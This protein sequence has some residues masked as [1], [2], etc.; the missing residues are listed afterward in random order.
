[1]GIPRAIRAEQ[2]SQSGVRRRVV[3]AGRV[4]AERFLL[5]HK[6]ADGGMGS[7]YVASDLHTGRRVAVK[8]LR[9][10]VASSHP[11]LRQ[12][13]LNEARTTMGIDSSHVVDILHVGEATPG[14]TY[15]VMELLEGKPL[16]EYDDLG[17]GDI[18]TVALQLCDGLAAA[19]D[20]G[21]VHRDLK[22]ENV[23]VCRRSDGS[24]HCE[25]IDFGIAKTA[26]SGELTLPGQIMGTPAYIAP[27]Q[28]RATGQGI[29][30]RTDIY[31]V[32]VLL[33]ELLAGKLPFSGESVLDLLR[34]HVQDEPAPLD[35]MVCPPRL[36]AVVM[37]CLRK[38]PAARYG[39]MR[40]LAAALREAVPTLSEPPGAPVPAVDSDAMP[41]I[42]K[43]VV[44]RSGPPAEAVPQTLE[45]A[46]T[47][48]QAP[49]LAPRARWVPPAM[50]L[51]A[52]VSLVGT[53]V[54]L[55]VS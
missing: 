14:H 22:P 36:A 48:Y 23:M 51:V 37:R 39:S 2:R 13:F 54:L 50:L 34:A 42:V 15:F 31:S 43:T 38:N 4:L 11:Q 10:E 45:Q 49:A 47:L 18:V 5:G 55:L 12:R 30:A 40:E 53:A 24:L 26:L 7:V 20:Q 44:A 25:L 35:P 28:A 17:L 3:A 52:L 1:M 9:E 32:G 8:M 27:E 16:E 46:L 21:I 41:T 19:H 6:L 29:D 33:Y